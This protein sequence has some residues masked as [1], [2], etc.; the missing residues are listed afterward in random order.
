MTTEEQNKLNAQHP[1][2]PRTEEGKAASS[3]NAITHGL[4][5][6]TALLPG[7][8]RTAYQKLADGIREDWQC[9]S[10]TQSALVLELI[11]IQW[12]LLRVPDIEARIL[13]APSPDFKA[14]NNISLYAGRLKRQYSAT[15]KELIRLSELF[16]AGHRKNLHNAALIHHADLLNHRPSSAA[17][18]GFV[19]SNA[20]LDAYIHRTEAIQDAIATL[21]RH[22]L[23]WAA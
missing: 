22:N 6:K 2:G 9:L 5:S 12:R 20:E 1:T 18:F 4:T 14:L 16:E 23:N 10:A 19:F 11:D 15:L 7:E 17:S 13:S 8:D 3:Q 21:D